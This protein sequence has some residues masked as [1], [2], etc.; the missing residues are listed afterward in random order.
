M[1]LETNLSIQL[2]EKMIYLIPVMYN[3]FCEFILWFLFYKK[4]KGFLRCFSEQ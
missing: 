1:L 3:D 4:K 2:L